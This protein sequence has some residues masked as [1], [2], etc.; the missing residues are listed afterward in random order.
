MH[1]SKVSAVKEVKLTVGEIK[2]LE[3]KREEK[4]LNKMIEMAKR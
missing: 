4:E 2:M 1:K 3:R